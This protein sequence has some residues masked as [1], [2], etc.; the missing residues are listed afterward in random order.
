MKTAVQHPVILCSF[1]ERRRT[2]R[3]LVPSQDSGISVH[4]AATAKLDVSSD[5]E[6]TLSA[7]AD[8]SFDLKTNQI[9]GSR[10]HRCRHRRCETGS[11]SLHQFVSR[12]R[13]ASVLEVCTIK[14]VLFQT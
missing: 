12:V 4:S 9:W 8:E 10:G 1:P 5:D 14:A 2:R 13:K 6:V 3:P 7:A 11:N